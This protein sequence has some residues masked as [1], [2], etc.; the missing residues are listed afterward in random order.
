MARDSD[1]KHF[2]AVIREL[3]RD[4]PTDLPV[5]VKRKPL[6]DLIGIATKGS[7]CYY[8]YIDSSLDEDMAV[9]SLLHE[10]THIHPYM[11]VG[12]DH[13]RDW[14]VRYA[15]IYQTYEKRHLKD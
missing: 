1:Y 14:G 15:K 3:R 8:I 13:G 9:Y 6:K 5:I 2:Y 7:K 4:F 12:V 11:M 10:W